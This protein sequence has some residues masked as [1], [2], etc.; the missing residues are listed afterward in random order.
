MFDIKWI[1]ENAE[2]FDRGLVSRGL[3]PASQQAIALDDERRAHLAKL[4]EAQARR[5]AASKQIGKTKA[6]KDEETAQKLMAEVAELKGVIQTG[7]EEERRV[8]QAIETLLSGLPNIPLEEVPVGKD[9]HD[10]QLVRTV[11]EPPK[12][13]YKPKE[14]FELGEALGLMDFETA[15]KISGARFVVLKGALARMERALA[16]FMLDVH[17]T[18]YGYTEVNPPLLVRD[19]A[20]YGTANLPDKHSEALTALHAGNAGNAAEA[21]ADDIRQ[22]MGQVGLTLST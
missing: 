1:R 14:H 9:E 22:G 16:Q 15:S 10:N 12:F 4:Q 18:E 7:E 2:A 21:I 3:E 6:Q 19:Q 20:A 17:T 5:N 8:D 11:G 13:D